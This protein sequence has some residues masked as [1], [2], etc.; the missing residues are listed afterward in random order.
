MSPRATHRARGGA[1]HARSSVVTASCGG[2]PSC[3][4]PEHAYQ[5]RVRVVLNVEA[6]EKAKRLIRRGRYIAD[7]REAWSAHRPPVEEENDF[8]IDRG[9][10]EYATWYLGVDRGEHHDVKAKYKFPYSDFEDVHRCALVA[11]ES[12]ARLYGHDDVASAAHELIEMIDERL[13][14]QPGR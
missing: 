12:S 8:L 2:P 5:F 3:S 6:F 10:E 11:V 4:R 7:E 13:R 1:A 14:A 9:W